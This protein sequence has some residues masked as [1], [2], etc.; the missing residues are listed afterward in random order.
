MAKQEPNFKLSY[1]PLTFMEEG[2]L[3]LNADE[4]N[5]NTLGHIYDQSQVKKEDEIEQHLHDL[6]HR[7]AKASESGSYLADQDGEY[8]DERIHPDTEVQNSVRADAYTSTQAVL[9]I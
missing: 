2:G 7:V 8:L 3:R 9:S 1:A 5:M 4:V 6:A